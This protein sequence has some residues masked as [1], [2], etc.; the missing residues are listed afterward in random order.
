M[1]QKDSKKKTSKKATAKTASPDFEKSLAELEALV[2][3]ME[4]GDQTLEQSLKDFERGVALTRNCQQAL[5][6]AEQ[7]VEQLLQQNGQEELAPFEPD[8]Q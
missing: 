6:T 3:R 4:Q 8:D 7:K 2:E 5:K 1:S